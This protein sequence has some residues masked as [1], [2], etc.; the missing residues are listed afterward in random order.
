[1]E[2]LPTEVL[3]LIFKNISGDTLKNCREV[4]SRWNQIIE[5]FIFSSSVETSSRNKKLIHKMLADGKRFEY[6]ELKILDTYRST[7]SSEL[8]AL[9]RTNQDHLKQ[10]SIKMVRQNM[11]KKVRKYFRRLKNLTDL[12]IDLFQL[13]NINSLYIMRIPYEL[14][15]LENLTLTTNSFPY[16][17]LHNFPI[18]FPVNLN[19]KKLTLL[20]P[21]KFIIPWWILS[22]AFPNLT[23]IDISKIVFI[24]N[25][26]TQVNFIQTN[27]LNIR[28]IKLSNVT[29]LPTIVV[30]SI[31]EIHIVNQNLIP[32]LSSFIVSNPTLKLINIQIMIPPHRIR[33]VTL[34]VNSIAE[35]IPN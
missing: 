18:L 19:L 34:N 3:I 10:L 8:E 9:L 29:V 35:I 4:C 22:Q 17:H 6:I 32:Q 28:V 12:T 13:Y 33:I 30:P 2:P 16:M 7:N 24:G 23:H 1:M 31:E 11:T 21:H 15:K 14:P 5:K 26:D 25:P 20:D 27:N